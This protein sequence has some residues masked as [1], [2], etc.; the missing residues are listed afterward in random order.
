VNSA[1]P[2]TLQEQAMIELSRWIS[3]ALQY[4]PQHPLCA[5][6][7]ARTHEVLLAALRE[8]M[9]LEIGVLRD[10][11]TIG[12]TPTRH[13]VLLT[14]LAPYLHER[15]VLVLRFLDGLR[16]EELSAVTEILTKPAADIFAA[17]GLRGLLSDRRVAH[18][19]IEEIGHELS[20][21]DK[22]QIRREEHVRELFREMLMR[23]LSN[24]AVP[25]EIGAHIAELAD[26]PD[27]AV[28][29]IQSEKHVNLAEAV[30]AFTVI[31]LQEEQRCGEALL[32]KMG[33]ILMQLA[34]ESRDRVLL[35]LP[36]LV[37]D[38]R[39]A[40]ASAL[41][42]LDDTQLAR[43]AL[44]SV[45]T[46]VSDL[47]ATFYALSV[48]ATTDE[49]RAG[50]GRAL[51]R[52]LYD[53]S[54]DERTT[55]ETLRAIATPVDDGPSF[56]QERVH[57]A[58]AARRILESRAPLHDRHDEGLI[59]ASAFTPA[60]FDRLAWQAAL[61]VVIRSSRMVDFDKLCAALPAAA[62][63]L[64]SEDHAPA[65]AGLLLGL[66]AVAEPRWSEVAGKTLELIARS[67]ISA[68]ALRAAERLASRG[69]DASIDDVVALARMLVTHNPEPV[70][71]LLERCDSRK[72]RRALL[73]ALAT[74]GPELLPLV[75]SRMQSS[76]WFVTRNMIVLHARLGGPAAELRVLAD[77]PHVQVRVEIVRAL[78]T[79]ARDP[80]AC[81]IVVHRLSDPA[82]DVAQAAIAS[83]AT[84]EL[85]PAAVGALEAL[86]A[87]EARS[88]DDRRGAVQ[89]LGRSRSDAAPEALARLIQ[90]H[91]LIERP[92]TTALRDDVARALR[93][94]PAA[95][96]AARFA[97]ALRS[98]AWRVR[99]SCERIA[100]EHG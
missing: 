88:D 84:M 77:H 61:D 26:H 83:L 95:G 76:S 29:V 33:P 68:L 12:K 24:G 36:P 67:G 52:L 92:S 27:L 43:F 25:P 53:L 93:Q 82:P 2:P 81:D 78:R 58:E 56:N 66:A 8:W 32:E 21:E 6:L 7:G 35:G 48:L 98:S 65:V 19:Q 42:V 16:A 4:S 75:Q 69:D 9:P 45:R 13:P 39:Q 64:S 46:R 73:D 94:C 72:L 31:L 20:I 57:L 89:V 22:E 54:L 80:V 28:R 96:A 5:Q 99:K 63:S 49:R 85:T 91:G 87:D 10:Q 50:L 47:D 23:M 74:G 70:V 37:G 14:R 30:A 97:E 3:R 51:G 62:R 100:G 71:D 59:D 41:G 18:V 38:F 11:L 44:Q 40:L 17:G 90:P 15:G 79:M 86:A 60:A 55:H 34:P 1:P